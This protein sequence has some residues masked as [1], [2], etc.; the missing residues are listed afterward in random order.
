L[1]MLPAEQVSRTCIVGL[2][3]GYIEMAWAQA[4]LTQERRGAS[5]DSFE[6][7]DELKI[8]FTNWAEGLE[9]NS[10]VYDLVATKLNPEI[11]ISDVQ[12]TIQLHLAGDSFIYGDLQKN[13]NQQKWNII[14]YDAFSQKTSHP[15][16]QKE[17]LQSFIQNHADEDCVFTTYAC[18][19]VLRKVLIENGFHF[20]KR[21]GFG[22]KRESSLAYR[23]VFAKGFNLAPSI[24]Q[25][26]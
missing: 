16:W 3:L 26:F 2:G 11:K 13:L 6:V 9:A 25:T 18:T 4:V 5:F 24:F 8:Y 20:I 17:F 7:V 10:S 15:L 12:K 14:C 19:G 21:Q 23:G 22:G 1:Q